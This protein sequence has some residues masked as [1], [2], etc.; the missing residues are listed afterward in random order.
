M[1]QR[2]VITYAHGTPTP[3]EPLAS[4]PQET[5]EPIETGNL[6]IRFPWHEPLPPSE[7]RP[8]QVNASRHDS[9]TLGSRRYTLR[10]NLMG[11]PVVLKSV[12]KILG[13][14]IRDHT[15]ATIPCASMS[16]SGMRRIGDRV[17]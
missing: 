2:E 7:L 9:S 17:G 6:R 14:V 4:S 3:S 5:W 11:S 1:A 12:W 13:L 8:R 16:P 15:S 10:F